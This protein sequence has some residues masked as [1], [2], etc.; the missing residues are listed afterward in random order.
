MNIGN[1][2]PSKYEGEK[3]SRNTQ[4][5]MISEEQMK[6]AI[7]IYKRRSSQILIEI[8]MSIQKHSKESMIR[9]ILI[10]HT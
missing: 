8:K 3:I 2:T 5:C 10:L 4:Q 7:L 6:I 1:V 9:L